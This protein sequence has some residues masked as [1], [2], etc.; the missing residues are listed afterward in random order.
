M[1]V[2][3]MI[4]FPL[5]DAAL[6]C[7]QKAPRCAAFAAGYAPSRVSRNTSGGFVRKSDDGRQKYL[8]R[9]GRKILIDNIGCQKITQ[10]LSEDFIGPVLFDYVWWILRQAQVREIHTLYFL[11]RD[12]YLL[13]EIA[14]RLCSTFHLPIKCRYLYVSRASLRM[15]TYHLIGEEAMDL[16]TLGGYQVTVR[17]LMRRAELTEEQCAAVC[18][19]CNVGYL[20]E[21]CLLSRSGLNEWRKMLRGSQLFREIVF[22]KSQAAYGNAIGY[23]RQEG[24]F[25]QPVVAVVDSGWTGSMQRSLRQLLQSAGFTGKLCGFYFGMYTPP[26]SCDDGVYLTWNFDYGSSPRWKVPFCNNL[27]ES[28]LTA[29]HGMTVS[30]RF[31]D[32]KYEPNQFPAPEGTELSRIQERGRLVIECVDDRLKGLDY[33]AFREKDCLRR[34]RKLIRRYM[35]YPTKE[36]ADYWGQFTFCDDTSES[37]QFSLADESQIRI[38][39]GYSIP[40]RIWKRLFPNRCEEAPA[41]YWPYGTIAFL[42]R[43]KRWWYRLNIYVWEWL[44]YM[45]R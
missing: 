2:A 38:L 5:F 17:S 7:C 13:K 33:D 24:L 25:D 28:I 43:W 29:P 42:P 11:A 22:K 36:E 10:K 8:V 34:T 21:D 18:A 4:S 39:K 16:L 27:F 6:M 37:Y 30:Y 9:I 1:P 15:P 3:A 20:A 32:G 40:A 26:K 31:H 23:L 14:Q 12:G 45:L 19:D 41:L 35:A 44:R